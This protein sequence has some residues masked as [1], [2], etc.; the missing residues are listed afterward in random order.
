MEPIPLYA[1][2]LEADNQAVLAAVEEARGV[3]E[4]FA[5]SG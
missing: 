2:V 3:V 1:V 5:G 4:G